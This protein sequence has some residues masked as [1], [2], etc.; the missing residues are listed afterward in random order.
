[1]F[2]VGGFHGIVTQTQLSQNLRGCLWI[3]GKSVL[4]VNHGLGD[5]SIKLSIGG[6]W[7]PANTDP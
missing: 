5:L 3:A 6:W 1:M 2:E 7:M 4:V